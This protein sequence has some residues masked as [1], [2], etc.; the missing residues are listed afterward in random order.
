ML[1]TNFTDQS[2]DDKSMGGR[3]RSGG[4]VY[5]LHGGVAYAVQGHA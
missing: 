3:C 2:Y 1:T 5:A 4:R